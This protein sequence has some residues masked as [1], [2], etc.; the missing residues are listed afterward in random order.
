MSSTDAVNPTAVNTAVARTE[1]NAAATS[2]AT[3]TTE[4]A[5]LQLRATGLC[6]LEAW[7]R[8][9]D[10]LAPAKD[11]IAAAPNFAIVFAELAWRAGEFVVARDI[12]AKWMPDEAAEQA[13]HGWSVKMGWIEPANG[14]ER[15]PGLTPDGGH[16]KT[17]P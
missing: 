10:V 7:G 16:G 13:T 12:L 14:R 5:R 11:E 1:H 3:A 15:I 9:Y 17:E 2:A 8:A 4:A 6:T